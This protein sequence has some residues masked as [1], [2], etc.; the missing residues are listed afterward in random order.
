MPSARWSSRPPPPTT[1]GA[2]ALTSR[3]QPS[4]RLGIGWPSRFSRTGAAAEISSSAIAGG[5]GGSRPAAPPGRSSRCATG[6]RRARSMPIRGVARRG[7]SSSA[8]SSSGGGGDPRA[9]LPDGKR[10][11]PGKRAWRG[12]RGGP[13]ALRRSSPLSAADRASWRCTP[14]VSAIFS[15]AWRVAP[16][17]RGAAVPLEMLLLVRLAPRR[18][19][20]ARSAR[21]VGARLASL[22]ARTAAEGAAPVLARWIE[23]AAPAPN[24]RARTTATSLSSTSHA[25]ARKPEAR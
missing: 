23:R 3:F 19:R 22:R 10:V 2:A 15:R 1:S 18:N 20:Q 5:R 4:A 7:A 14:S 25:R 12:A 6:A 8:A 16:H 9:E 11:T 21:H 24:E 17:W 13:R